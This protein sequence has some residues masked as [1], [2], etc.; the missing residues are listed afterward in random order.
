[1]K[2]IEPVLAAEQTQAV[3]LGKEYG[4]AGGNFQ[5]IGQL[6]SNLMPPTFTFAMVVVLFYFLYAAY[7]F[8]AYA[9]NKEELAKARSMIVNSIVGFLLLMFV[10]ILAQF[11]PQFIFQ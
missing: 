9:G 10:F 2:L 3:D 11:I 6:I 5:N 8:I 1:M 7:K 4:F